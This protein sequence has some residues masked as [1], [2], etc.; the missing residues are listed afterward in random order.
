MSINFIYL[1]GSWAKLSFQTYTPVP[2]TAL[3]VMNA[4]PNSTAYAL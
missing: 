3:Q 2:F 4:Y 1:Y